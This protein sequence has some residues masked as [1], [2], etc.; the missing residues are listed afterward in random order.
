MDKSRDFY[1]D[2]GRGFLYTRVKNDP[3]FW[4]KPEFEA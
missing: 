2:W 1:H 4:Q 3:N